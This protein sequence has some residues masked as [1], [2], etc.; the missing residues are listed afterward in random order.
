MPKAVRMNPMAWPSWKVCVTSTFDTLVSKYKRREKQGVNIALESTVDVF[1][2]SIFFNFWFL[3]I[4][5]I[6]D[7]SFVHLHFVILHFQIFLKTPLS[8]A[9]SS[10]YFQTSFCS[11]TT[12]SILHSSLPLSPYP[13]SISHGWHPFPSC[14]QW[15]SCLHL[16]LQRRRRFRKNN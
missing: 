5:T 7:Q 11:N 10:I 16:W 14:L 9:S 4:F 13:S 15:W 2:I 6:I 8:K 3:P 12:L 1:D